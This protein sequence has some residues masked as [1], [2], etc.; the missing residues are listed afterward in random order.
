MAFKCEHDHYLVDNDSNISTTY[1]IG[2]G[3]S[4]ITMAKKKK[5]LGRRE[6]KREAGGTHVTMFLGR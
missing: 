6:E 3:M 4:I 5:K 2:R 1:F